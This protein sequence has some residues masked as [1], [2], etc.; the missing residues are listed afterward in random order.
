M[1]HGD[2]TQWDQRHGERCGRVVLRVD[3]FDGRLLVITTTTRRYEATAEAD[4]RLGYDEAVEAAGQFVREARDPIP[5]VTPD[6]LEI[7]TEKLHVLEAV[8]TETCFVAVSSSLLSLK[9]AG[10]IDSDFSKP[11]PWSLTRAGRAAFDAV[12]AKAQVPA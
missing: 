3:P 1:K 6:Q 9:D 4:A 8:A 7:A 5:A 2:A 12:R 11:H 10:L